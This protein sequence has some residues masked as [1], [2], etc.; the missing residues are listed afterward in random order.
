[1][2]ITKTKTLRG[3]ALRKF[4][5]DYGLPCSI[6]KSSLAFRECIWLGVDDAR[7]LVMASQAA[8]VGV[9]T[10]Q[11][12]GWVPYPVPECVQ[13]STRMHLTQAQVK[14]LIPILQKFV[15]TGEL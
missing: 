6:Q 7:P 8:S 4:E 5:D 13:L 12:T 9:K 15:D 2:N 14:K 1:M 3:F 11:T 10:E